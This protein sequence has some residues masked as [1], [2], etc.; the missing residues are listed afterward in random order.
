[1]QVFNSSNMSFWKTLGNEDYWKP[2]ESRWS[3]TLMGMEE[4][5]DYYESV[6]RPI[7]YTIIGLIPAFFVVLVFF[8]WRLRKQFAWDNY[9][10]FSADLRIRNALITSSILLT[11]LKLDFFFVFSF[12]AQLIPSVNL[13]YSETITETVLV[14]VLGALFLSLAIISVYQESEYGLGASILTGIGSIGYFIYRVYI[15]AL[16]RGN[17]YDPYLHTRQFLIFTTVVAMVLLL[18]TIIVAIKCLLNIHRGTAIYRNAALGKNKPTAE[19]SEAIDHESIDDDD[20][21]G[22]TNLLHD[23]KKSNAVGSSNNNQENLWSIE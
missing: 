16:P 17:Q 20:T 18:F 10:N 7:E 12:A 11:L 21:H 1:M 9:R 19:K 2:V 5:K 14:F 22:E 6:M 3:A 15:I 8:G 23:K 4:A 13:G